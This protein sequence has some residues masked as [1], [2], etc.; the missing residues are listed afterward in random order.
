MKSMLKLFLVAVMVLSFTGMSFAQAKPATPAT[1]SSEKM[2]KKDD[3][4]AKAK[5]KAKAKKAEAK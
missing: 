1:P 2:D 3:G 4:K 5:A